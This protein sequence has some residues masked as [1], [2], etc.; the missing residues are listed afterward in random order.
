MR[1]QAAIQGDFNALLQVEV[2]AGEKVVTTGVR[3]ASD[4]LKIELRAQITGVGLGTRLA[5]TWRG[6]VYPKGRPRIAAAGFVFSKASGIV[7]LYAEGG[8]IRSRQGSCVPRHPDVG[9]RQVRRWPAEDHRGADFPL[10]DVVFGRH[11]A[12]PQEE[13]ELSPP[14][15]DRKT[16]RNVSM[17]L[18]EL[19]SEF[20]L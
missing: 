17:T 8:L 7:R 2:R 19:G 5:N 3:V 10:G 4:G 11:L 1:F 16:A 13:E 9:R 18:R 15:L 14:R 20:R 6:E 12:V